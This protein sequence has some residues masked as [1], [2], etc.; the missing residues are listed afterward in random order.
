MLVF[1]FLRWKA[2]RWEPVFV[3]QV[4]AARRGNEELSG[5]VPIPLVFI[6]KLSL[7]GLVASQRGAR[8]DY[9]IGLM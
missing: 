8:P 5:K 7:A 2:G 4:A 6:H 9:P 3:L 1:L